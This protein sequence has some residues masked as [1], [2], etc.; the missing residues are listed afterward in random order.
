[1]VNYSL[2]SLNKK[3][4][5]ISKIIGQS[6]NEGGGRGG[7]GGGFDGNVC[8][9]TRWS[10][11]SKCDADC[12]SGNQYRQRHFVNPSQAEDCRVELS[13]ERTCTSQQ[14]PQCANNAQSGMNIASDYL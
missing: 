6:S 14:Q 8:A 11:W 4:I 3:T 7:G 2:N 9:T 12:G 10:R 5:F 13:E 1:M